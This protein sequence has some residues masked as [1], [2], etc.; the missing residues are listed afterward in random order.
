[1]RAELIQ[2]VSVHSTFRCLYFYLLL[3]AWTHLCKFQ[4]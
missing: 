3:N 1:M 2:A 4:F